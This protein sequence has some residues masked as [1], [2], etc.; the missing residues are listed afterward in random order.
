MTK[1]IKLKDNSDN[2]LKIVDTDHD[3]AVVEITKKT[4]G[5][6]SSSSSQDF[7]FD[8]DLEALD[9]KYILI[10]DSETGDIIGGG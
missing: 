8:G 5:S 10:K 9:G 2:H 3:I 1:Y 4:D 7:T 6:S